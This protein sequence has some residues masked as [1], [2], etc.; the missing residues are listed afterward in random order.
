MDQQLLPLV[1]YSD[2]DRITDT[3]H[4]S[5]TI[6]GDSSVDLLADDLIY[7]VVFTITRAADDPHTRPCIIHWNPIEDGCNQSGMILLYHGEGSVEFREVDPEEL[8][9]KLL[10]PRQVT[11]SDPYFRELVPGSRVFCKVPLPAAYLKNCGSEAAYLLLWP[12]GQIPLWDWGTLAEHSEH[13]LVP[14]SPPVILPGPSYESFATFNYES[15]P[16][17]FEDPPPPS[18]RAI[19]PSA[20]VHGAP[21]FNVR[22]SGPATLSMKD[23]AFSMPRYPLTVT[24]SYDAGAELSHSNRPITFR[25]FIF[26]QP[27]DHHQGYR[28]YREWNDGWTPYEWR[29]HQRGFIITEPT[30]LNV[31]RNDENNFWTLKPGESWSFTRKVSEFPKDAASGDKFRYLF[32]GA[33]LDWWNWGS[34]EDHEDT[35]IWV[36]GWLLAKVQYPEDNDGRPTVVVPA[37]NAV[38][39][40]LVD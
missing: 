19:S 14:K 21:V 7:N 23:Q 28:L 1:K 24:V 25:S 3:P 22:I 17:Y 10:I 31:G 8:P 37:S 29:T 36:P 32:K 16:E 4:L 38:E 2:K 11:A 13:K 15:D 5:L 30:A 12:G 20:R 6:R 26:K 9:T 33:T 27:D 18:P 34:L 35:V 39:F 40:T